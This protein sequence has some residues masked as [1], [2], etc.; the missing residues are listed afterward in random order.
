MSLD[1]IAPLVSDAQS[2]ASSSLTGYAHPDYA[3]SFARFGQPIHLP[4]SNGWLLTRLIQGTTL[5]DAM[6]CY[7][8]FTCERWPKLASDLDEIAPNLVSLVVVPDPFGAFDSRLLEKCF[9]RV[10][11]LK[12]HFV[13]DL[14]YPV[15]QI[16]KRSHRAT[17]R[18]ALN[19]VEVRVCPRPWEYLDQWVDLFANLRKRRNIQGIR[20]FSRETFAL[21]LKIPGLV[22]FE[23]LAEGHT[24]G[25]DLWYVQGDVAYGHLVS[26]SEE[27][28]KLRASYATKWTMLNYFSDKIRWIDLGGGAG[29]STNVNDGLTQFKQGWSNET[30]PV[31][32]CGRIFQR[33][34]YRELCD[35]IIVGQSTHFPAYRAGEFE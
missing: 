14:S 3:A 4:Q 6:G 26:F 25:L 16:V 17:V 34:Q 29:T 22:M 7:P 18:R 9:D 32:L 5:R 19:K 28:Y 23:A 8:L 11:H 13:A 10:V 12:D 15:N 30:K 35:A 33:D 21:Q 2:V 24:V 1:D 27:G 31:H 20:A